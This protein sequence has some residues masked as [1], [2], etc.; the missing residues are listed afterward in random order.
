VPML[1]DVNLLLAL[2][3]DRH[4][5]HASAVRWFDTLAAGDALVCRIAQMG[6]LRLLNN[7]TVMQEETLTVDAC[8]DVWKRMLEDE[9]I[10][11]TIFE[12]PNLDAA[13]EHLMSGRVFSPRLWTDAYLAAFANTGGLILATF[14]QGFRTFSG[15]ACEVLE[16]GQP[17][18]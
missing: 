11:F 16:P 14:D 18:H 17:Q 4:A 6:L 1:C 12:P 10:Q 15:L 5:H 9:R 13:F 3:T 2:V 8:W 7:P